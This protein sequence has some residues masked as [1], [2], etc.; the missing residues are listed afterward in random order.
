MSKSVWGADN[1][2]QTEESG[3]C[4]CVS[5]WGCGIILWDWW[6]DVYDIGW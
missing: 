1:W 4:A 6:W 5:E 3:A 2:V